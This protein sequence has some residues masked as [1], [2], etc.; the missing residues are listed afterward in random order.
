MRIEPTSLPGVLLVHPA[1]FRDERGH[2]LEPFNARDFEAAGLP[3]R[4][5]QDNQSCSKAGVLRGLHLQLPPHAQG[6][7]VRVARGAALDVAVD[8]RR[9]SPTFGKW[10]S[11]LLSAENNTMLWIPEGFAHGFLSL[12]DDTVFTYKCTAYYHKAA[13]A[14]IRWN[15]PELAIDWGTAE[16]V[17]SEKD[18]MAPFFRDLNSPF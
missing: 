4:F 2:F 6:K 5:V 8:L 18:A 1:V 14:S 16:P 9:T 7:L 10:T 13:E 15:D 11:V 3:S 12:E 17:L